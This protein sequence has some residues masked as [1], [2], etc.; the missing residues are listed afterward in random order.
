MMPFSPSDPSFLENPFPFYKLGQAISP[1]FLPDPGMWLVFG[2]ND[3]VSILKDNKTW[4]SDFRILA[5]QRDEFQHPSMLNSDEP[6][7]GQ[8]RGLVSQAFTPRMVEQLEPRVREIAREL[9]DA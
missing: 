2:Y 1:L 4:S 6:R 5:P 7:H 3:C 9:L 8:L